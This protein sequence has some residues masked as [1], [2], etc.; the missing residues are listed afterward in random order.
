MIEHRKD[1]KGYGMHLAE[2]RNLGE[3]EKIEGDS[4]A[5]KRQQEV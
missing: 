4:Y 2:E 3:A 1:F 5:Q